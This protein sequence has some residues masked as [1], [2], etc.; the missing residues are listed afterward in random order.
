MVAGTNAGPYSPERTDET[1]LENADDVRC[2]CGRVAD[3]LDARD[4]KPTCERCARLAS[5][6][7]YVQT[8]PEPRPD[9]GGDR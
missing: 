8:G 5:T 3:G 1:P 4:G 7:G 6:V 9:D 2:A